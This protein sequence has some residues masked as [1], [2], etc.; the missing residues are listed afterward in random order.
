MTSLG[1][2]AARG[3]RP[4]SRDAPTLQSIGLT[5]QCFTDPAASQ[6][7]S[8]L[9]SELADQLGSS[10]KYLNAHLESMESGLWWAADRSVEI[11]PPCHGGGIFRIHA[12]T[13]KRCHRPAVSRRP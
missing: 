2:R 3:D 7:T 12:S 13:D 11:L 1:R 4:L 6:P 9:M 5:A 10:A 8:A